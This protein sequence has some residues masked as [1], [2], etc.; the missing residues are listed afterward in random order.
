MPHKH[1]PMPDELPRD[2]ADQTWNDWVQASGTDPKS[3]AWTFY[4]EDLSWVY[5]RVIRPLEARVAALENRVR[6]LEQTGG[7]PGS[8][9]EAQVKA[10]VN[11]AVVHVD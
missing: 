10:I 7:R 6:A 8:L 2:W 1:T 4:R 3:R 5:T 9:N 11:S